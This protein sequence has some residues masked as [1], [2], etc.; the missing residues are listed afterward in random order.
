MLK[1]IIRA[2]LIRNKR[3]SFKGCFFI[4]MNNIEYVQ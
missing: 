2:L 1:V 4:A 3:Q